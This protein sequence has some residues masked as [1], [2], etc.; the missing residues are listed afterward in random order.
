MPNIKKNVEEVEVMKEDDECSKNDSSSENSKSENESEESDEASSAAALPP[1]VVKKQEMK[2]KMKKTKESPPPKKA[3]KKMT[4]SNKQD[5]AA[6]TSGHHRAQ[7]K[8]KKTNNY[9]IYIYKVFKQ[10]NEESSI[11]TKAM[12]VINDFMVDIFERIAREAAELCKKNQTKTLGSREIQ[13]AVKLL[14]PGELAK[15]AM[16]EGVCQYLTIGKRERERE[17]EFSSNEKEESF[18]SK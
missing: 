15:H 10:I 14:F 5:S 3:K 18:L 12:A 2:R 17:R 11:S 9:S 6:S 16:S 1:V 4:T 8:K 7:P 13:T